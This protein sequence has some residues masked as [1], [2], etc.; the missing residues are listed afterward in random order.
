MN[1]QLF[2]SYAHKDER[3]KDALETHLKILKRQGV[4]TD[5]NDRKIA[6]G[7]D[8]KEEIDLNL[9]KAKIVLLLISSN[10]LASDYC[11][12]TETIY[13]LERHKKKK[14][15][16]IPIIIKPCLWQESNF[17]HLQALPKDG[18]PVSLWRD[19]DEAWL[20]VAKGIANTIQQIP[21][22]IHDDFESIVYGKEKV[23]AK[24]GKELSKQPLEEQLQTFLAT[25]NRWYISPLRIQ[26]WGS[27]Q[28]GFEWL[29]NYS[30]RSIRKALEK[31]Y[32][33]GHLKTTSS[34]KGNPLYKAR[35]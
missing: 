7:S 27:K 15:V 23:K 3:F 13:A 28:K 32:E 11:Y 14:S 6:P 18:K 10:F 21:T 22:L 1:V 24:A 8:W 17:K 30:T 12:D 33:D 25:Y 34:K 5:W 29:A 4:I 2:Y 20:F 26:K 31:L 9:E 19:K 16:V 35:E